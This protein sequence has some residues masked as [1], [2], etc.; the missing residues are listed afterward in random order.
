MAGPFTVKADVLD[1]A[2][3]NP[4]PPWLNLWDLG[5]LVR[6]GLAASGVDGARSA[7]LSAEVLAESVG[8]PLLLALLRQ[9]LHRLGLGLPLAEATREALARAP[10]IPWPAVRPTIEPPPAPPQPEPARLRLHL[11]LLNGREARW[12]EGWPEP[13]GNALEGLRLVASSGVC[14]E[15]E[16]RRALG[17]AGLAEFNAFRIQ[18]LGLDCVLT[19]YVNGVSQYRLDDAVIGAWSEGSD[20]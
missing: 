10:L 16:L 14:S 11:R 1:A 3:Q 6:K 2:P 15:P 17:R 13:E 12:P 19:E 7:F 18:L 5:T 8:H 4:A 9:S 20:I